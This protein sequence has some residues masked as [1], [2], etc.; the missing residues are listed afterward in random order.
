MK[1]T[2]KVVILNIKEKWHQKILDGEKIIELRR[3]FVEDLPSE[4]KMFL[5]I[6]GWL[7]AGVEIDKIERLSL[8]EIKSLK[9]KHCADDTWVDEYFKGYDTGIAIHISRPHKFSNISRYANQSYGDVGIKSMCIEDF[10]LQ[11]PY[12]FQV[13]S[14]S[15]LAERFFKREKDIARRR[16]EELEKDKIRHTKLKEMFDI[17]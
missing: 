5:C 14:K 7:E 13:V 4:T 6:D 15:K 2:D 16:Q 1:D 17:T 12:S 10:G 3:D 8:E 11:T 9:D